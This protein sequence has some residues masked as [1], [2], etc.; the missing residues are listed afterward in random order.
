VH[1]SIPGAV[2]FPGAGGADLPADR[3]A[4]LLAR[5]AELTG[6]DKA[7]PVVSFCQPSCW[8]SWNVGKRLVLAGYTAVYWLPA[9]VAGWQEQHDTAIVA[10]EPGW[11]PA[12]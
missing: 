9:G 1:R 3:A 6:G 7:A 4:A 8:G 10:P 5:I 12:G 2:W 11:E